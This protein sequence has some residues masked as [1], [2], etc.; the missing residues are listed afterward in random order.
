MHLSKIFA[1]VMAALLL[2]A[3]GGGGE[4]ASPQPPVAV[5][6]LPASALVSS[7][8]FT[9]FAA[10]IPVTDGTEPMDVSKA[11]PAPSSDTTEPL[12]VD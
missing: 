8:S 4:P 2:Q 1:L 10:A 11:E 6:E 7:E 5:N 3:C 9:R 12:P